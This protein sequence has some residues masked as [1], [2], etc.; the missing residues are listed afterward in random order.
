MAAGYLTAEFSLIAAS[1]TRADF[2]VV[3]FME[4]ADFM[5]RERF[6][7]AL[8]LE[9]SAASIMEGLPEASLRAGGRVSAE[10]FMEAEDSTAVVAVGGNSFHYISK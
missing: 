1:V 3:G 6:M 4:R 5:E 10:D 7:V 8:V 9:R 2:M